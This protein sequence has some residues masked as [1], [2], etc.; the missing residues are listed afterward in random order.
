[1]KLLAPGLSIVVGL[2][3]GALVSR[4][5]HPPA[6]LTATL[7]PAKVAE[8]P[9]IAAPALLPSS[10]T[11]ET[12]KDP[13][14]PDRPARLAIWLPHATLPEIEALWEQLLA[15]Q[16]IPQPLATLVIARWVVLDPQGAMAGNLKLGG[17]LGA[18]EAWAAV[19]PRA[20]EAA[21]RA[22]NE[23]GAL[24]MV[25][26]GIAGRDPDYVAKLIEQ[27]LGLAQLGSNVVDGFIA[28]RRFDKALDFTLRLGSS[29]NSRAKDKLLREWSKDDP[30]QLLLWG[31]RSPRLLTSVGEELTSAIA[32]EQ[33]DKM[34]GILAKMPTGEVKGR[35]R[36]AYA[37]ALAEKDPAAAI[38]FAESEEAPLAAAALL[39]NLG[40]KF[41]TTQPAMA[42]EVL[43]KILESGRALDEYPVAVF[44]LEGQ[45]EGWHSTDTPFPGFAEDLIKN[46]PEL[47]MD[48][49]MASD[50]KPAYQA[51]A[52]QLA[53]D[54]M[55]KD[56]WDFGVWLKRQP[57][58]ALRDDLAL[59]YS[60]QL[61]NGDKPAY[62]QALSWT[63]SVADAK[64]RDSQI[65][66][67]LLQ[68]QGRDPAALRSYLSASGT[69]EIIR[70]RA[71]Q[72]DER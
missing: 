23:R 49:V 52:R 16:P 44:F 27:D 69:P 6:T 18:W 46:M 63:G 62:D 30:E 11:V 45:R 9:Q 70:S 58:G 35:L 20:A 68:W 59:K 5:L 13:D 60:S 19:D 34:P 25:L 54:W 7:A 1:M 24:Y 14:L 40:R 57:A 42:V 51:A 22:S 4:A 28:Q 53:N 21:A 56:E 31:A 67:L 15:N 2:T 61:A 33:I 3:A 39:G 32:R 37:T 12:L 41:T 55:E 72:M 29:T 43:G 8:R 65:D 10:D 26:Q 64:Q 38:R 71:K 66:Q 36:Q 50:D 17:T 47:A 48:A